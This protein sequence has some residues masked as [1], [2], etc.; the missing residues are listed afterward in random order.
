MQKVATFDEEYPLSHAYPLPPIMYITLPAHANSHL[1]RSI[2]REISWLRAFKVLRVRCPSSDHD[3][4]LSSFFH[5]VVPSRL[6]TSGNAQMIGQQ[7]RSPPPFYLA[8]A[9]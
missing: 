2:G 6:P 8:Y 9:P 4:D 5:F 7:M 1:H 3:G